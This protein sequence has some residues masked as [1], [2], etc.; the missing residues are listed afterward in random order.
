MKYK[1]AE[2]CFEK[3]ILL[4]DIEDGNMLEAGLWFGNLGQV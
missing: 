4:D 1:E 2:T 3:A